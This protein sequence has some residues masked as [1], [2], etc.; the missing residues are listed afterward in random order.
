MNITSSKHFGVGVGLGG[1]RTGGLEGWRPGVLGGWRAGGLW[2]WGAGRLEDWGAG[3]IV[4]IRLCKCQ[5]T[6][7]LLKC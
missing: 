2:G 6:L 7:F 1:W 3:T 4:Y 5:R